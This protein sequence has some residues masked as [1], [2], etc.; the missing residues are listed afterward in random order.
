M[1]NMGIISFHPHQIIESHEKYGNDAFRIKVLSA[2]S[3]KRVTYLPFEVLVNMNGKWSWYPLNLRFMNLP[4]RG[5]I[6][7]PDDREYTSIKLVFR[8]GNS[9]Y[10]RKVGNN[11][12]EENFGK[13]IQIIYDAFIFHVKKGLENN[14][15]RPKS[16]K[17]TI[18][19]IIQ[20]QRNG[21]DSESENKVTLDDPIIRAEIPFNQDKDNKK[22][23]PTTVRHEVYDAEKRLS[24]DEAK[25]AM[26]KGK[27]PFEVA[28]YEGNDIDYNNVQE[29]IRS[30][31]MCSGVVNMDSVSLSQQ[32]ISLPCRTSVLIVK[33]SKGYKPLPDETFTTDDFDDIGTAETLEDEEEPSSNNTTYVTAVNDDTQGDPIGDAINKLGEME[34]KN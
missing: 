6:P 5:K 2:R 25:K 15:V 13:A 29:F 16:G 21:K 20:T 32:G 9:T 34:N 28:K 1:S 19:S 31:S 12:K 24:P 26:E 4:T 18:Y 11:Y 27:Y 30:G 22:A 7:A 14:T 33:Q 23:D 3:T 8:M 17:D 10:K